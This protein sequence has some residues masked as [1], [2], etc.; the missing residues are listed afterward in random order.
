MLD[1]LGQAEGQQRFHES[2]FRASHFVAA[3]VY[4]GADTEV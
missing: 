1:R 3:G 4:I 2:L